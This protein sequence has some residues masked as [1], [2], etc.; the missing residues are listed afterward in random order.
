MFMMMMMMMMMMMIII[1]CR[2]DLSLDHPKYIWLKSGT[3]IRLEYWELPL[4]YNFIVIYRQFSPS[5]IHPLLRFFP[6]CICLLLSVVYIF[7]CFLFPFG[8]NTSLGRQPI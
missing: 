8:R 3:R 4:S 7:N 2:N 5:H 6:I 1:I